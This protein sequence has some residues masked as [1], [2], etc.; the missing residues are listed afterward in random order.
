M[1][2]LRRFAI[3]SL[4]L[5]ALA[6]GL[7][8]AVVFM[9]LANDYYRAFSDKMRRLHQLPGERAIAIGGSGLAFGMDSEAVERAIGR[10]VVNMGLH[11]GLGIDFMFRHV[12]PELRA[13]DLVVVIPEYGTLSDAG[14]VDE[15]VISATLLSEPRSTLRLVQGADLKPMMRG[16]TD[17]ALRRLIVDPGIALQRRTGRRTDYM[18]DHRSFDARG[19]ETG[20]LDAPS[21]QDEWKMTVDPRIGGHVD[22]LNTFAKAVEARGARAVFLYASLPES[23]ARDN[24]EAL[25]DIEATINERLVM[26]HI[27]RPSDA[28]QPDAN[29]FDTPN[30]PNVRGRAVATARI[31][32][33]LHGLARND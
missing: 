32:S 33:S 4:K 2:S 19:D 10:P 21:R 11:A 30:H 8:V 18:S 26:P 23:V 31:V 13:G 17:V 3:S 20:H 27:G 28:V 1:S 7:V 15:G 22:I 5:G 12:L 24:A 29:F 6:I 25:G 16:F 14:I 9:P